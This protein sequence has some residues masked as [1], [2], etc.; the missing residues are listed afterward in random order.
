[1]FSTYKEYLEKKRTQNLFI[2]LGQ[3]VHFRLLEE[4]AKKAGILDTKK[5]RMDFV[6]FGVVLGEDKKKFKT[7][8]GDTVK[9]SELLDE[10]EKVVKKKFGYIM[11]YLSK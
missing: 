3:G 7:R 10:G 6:G 4:C 11:I 1:M 2:D 5:T 8:S 9:L